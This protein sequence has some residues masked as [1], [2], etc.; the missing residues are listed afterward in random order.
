MSV[1]LAAIGEVVCSTDCSWTLRDA[2]L[3]AVGVGAGQSPDHELAFSTENS[4]GVEHEVLPTFACALVPR[5]PLAL[6]GDFSLRSIVHAE[7]SVSLHAPIPPEGSVTSVMR[8]KGLHDK[9]YGALIALETEMRDISY[10]QLVV[11]VCL[12]IFV[13]GEGGFG[14]PRGQTAVWQPP[15]RAPDAEV[16]YSIRPEQALIYRL[17]GDRN[18]LH[19]DPWFAR[20]AG[21]PRPIL[22]G[23]CTFGFAGRALLHTSCDSDVHRFG[24]MSARFVKP[25]YPGDSITV[26]L[27]AD[28]EHVLFQVRS[29]GELVL[30]RGALS[31]RSLGSG[32][33]CREH[34]PRRRRRRSRSGRA[35]REANS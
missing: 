15:N 26:A 10:G 34:C 3:Y 4:H 23:L 35:R 2:L 7:E 31:T 32:A 12:S 25:V 33:E 22:H 27:W 28:R 21:F 17:S 24:G 19:S 6:L 16:T 11:T 29:R 1:R 9:G 30:D 14:G 5:M 18:P 8:L 13:H 20:Q